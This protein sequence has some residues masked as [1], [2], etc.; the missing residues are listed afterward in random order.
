METK[1][2]VHELVSMIKTGQILEA[3][4]KFYAEGVEMAENA[5]PATVG[6]D[7][8][9]E[10]EIQFLSAV[11]EV[12]VNETTLVIV[13]GDQASIG[14]HLEFT[15]KDGIRIKIFQVAV[16]QWSNG[17]IVSERFYYDSA[18]MVVG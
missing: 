15:N 8:N 13:E 11:K 2:L 3:F 7:A 6:K 10:R 9:R 16:Q 12:H 14:Y 17:Q 1:Q 5:N 4:E 18:N